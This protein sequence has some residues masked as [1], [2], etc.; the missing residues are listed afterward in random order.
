MISV[1][2]TCLNDGPHLE[3]CLQ[4][5]G[6]FQGL[7]VR[8]VDGGSSESLAPRLA[9]MGPVTLL[10]SPPGRARQFNLGAAQAQGEVL[11]FLHSDSRLPTGWREEIGRILANPKNIAGAFSFK[12]DLDHPKMARIERWANRRSRYLQLPYGDQG[13]FMAKA[14]FEGLVGFA[15]LPLM[16]DYELVLRLKKQGR[17]ETSPLPLVTSGRRWLAQG[18]GAVGWTNFKIILLYHLGISPDR[19][20]KIYRS[21]PQQKAVDKQQKP[22]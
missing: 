6:G 1:V 2:L 7:E 10:H 5:L 11:L 13:L 8:V 19:L 21:G 3:A 22:G 16:E 20:Q 17:I 9:R 18:F 4:S 12:T 14:T 15:P